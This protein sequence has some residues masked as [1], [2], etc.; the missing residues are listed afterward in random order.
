MTEQ[1]SKIKGYDG[2]K[3]TYTSPHDSKLKKWIIG[4]LESL[5]GRDYLQGIYDQLHDE[6]PTPYNVWGNALRKLNIQ[7]DYDEEQLEKIP[8]EGPII[9]VAN[10]PF[11]IVDGAIFCHLVTRKRKDFF[12]LVNEVLSREPI[13]KEHLLP[14]DFRGNDEALQVNLRTKQL[15]TER[16][17]NGEA[18]II[19]PSGAISTSK[20]IF[21]KPKEWQWRRF[22][23]TR[24]H[25]TK[26]TVV[27]FY[28][29][30][31]NSRLFQ[32]ASL[33]SMNVR[34]GLLLHE[35]M[36]KRGKKFKVEIGDP[37]TYEEMAA[38]R[39]RQKLIE[40]LQDR[41]LSLEKK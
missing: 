7:I 24:I 33:F 30:G 20:F 15:T 25:E 29:Y 16:L 28:F 5:T 19:F 9:F 14:V 32:F 13:M 4:T 39:D 8:E 26:C 37:I 3:F 41:T 22:I 1:P 23:S 31:R 34:L 2:H 10:H 36:N 35:T 11:G 27:P 38:Y 12:I 18:L 40:F 17:R 6:D 21:D